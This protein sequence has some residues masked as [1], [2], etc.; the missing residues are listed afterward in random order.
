MPRR[1]V[2]D[3]KGGVAGAIKLAC[4]VDPQQV[5]VVL[6]AV[7]VKEDFLAVAIYFPTPL[8]NSYYPRLLRFILAVVISLL[9]F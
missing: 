1:A 4:S 6:R 5:A 7:L 2:G 3:T 8:G 9:E